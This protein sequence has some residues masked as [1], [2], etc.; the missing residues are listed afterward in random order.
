MRFVEYGKCLSERWNRPA[1][2]QRIH[3]VGFA[4]QDEVMKS[5][6]QK[7]LGLVRDDFSLANEIQKNVL[8]RCSPICLRKRSYDDSFYRPVIQPEE[9]SELLRCP[10]HSNG[11]RLFGVEKAYLWRNGPDVQQKSGFLKRYQSSRSR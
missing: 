4:F 1:S 9:H 3:Y 8:N 5:I 2:R 7:Y 11:N 6:L 10:W